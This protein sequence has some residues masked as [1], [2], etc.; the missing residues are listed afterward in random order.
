MTKTN[1][2]KQI[3][4]INAS[5]VELYSETAKLRTARDMDVETTRDALVSASGAHERLD[6][7]AAAFAALTARVR[8]LEAFQRAN[9]RR[10]DS[11]ANRLLRLESGVQAL[12]QAVE[13]RA[14]ERLDAEG[15][16]LRRAMREVLACGPG[17]IALGA[18]LVGFA[19][20]V[21]LV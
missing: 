10:A 14:V 16:A 13:R 5:L 9:M 3:S 1:A 12:N 19:L 15:T 17:V 21:W 8:D 11:N 6:K 18:A 20:G 2:S 4:G 7:A